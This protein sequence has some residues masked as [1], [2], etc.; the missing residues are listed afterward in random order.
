MESSI[1]QSIRGQEGPGTHSGGAG[2]NGAGGCGTG[3]NKGA[4]G[5][6]GL[7]NGILSGGEGVSGAAGSLAA[8]AAS[9]L[10][11]VSDNLVASF[12]SS[13]APLKDARPPQHLAY[14]KGTSTDL[15]LLP[16]V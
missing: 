6:H 12:I 11:T 8:T 5:S 1:M 14:R 9:A 15:S 10:G 7:G 13:Q 4:S 3:T 16:A 2:A